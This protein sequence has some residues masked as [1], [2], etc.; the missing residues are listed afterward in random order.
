MDKLN[1]IFLGLV[2]RHDLMLWTFGSLQPDHV[3]DLVTST[4]MFDSLYPKGSYTG[5]SHG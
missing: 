3:M 1:M 4:I 5:S 2:D